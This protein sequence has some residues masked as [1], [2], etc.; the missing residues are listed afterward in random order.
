M[1]SVGGSQNA[2]RHMWKPHEMH[3]TSPMS[4]TLSYVVSV[5]VQNT[6]PF[7]A[8]SLREKKTGGN[9]MRGLLCCEVGAPVHREVRLESSAAMVLD[10]FALPPMTTLSDHVSNTLLPG[11]SIKSH[12]E[13]PR[14]MHADRM[15]MQKINTLDLNMLALSS[16]FC[17]V[18]S[19]YIP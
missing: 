15:F 9:D 8:V 3:K 6:L 1:F 5:D 10:T 16:N 11:V 12:T 7:I 17:S 18:Y 13:S 4:T 19:S 14:N 2:A